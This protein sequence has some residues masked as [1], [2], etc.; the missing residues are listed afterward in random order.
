M[1]GIMIQNEDFTDLYI[2]NILSKNFLQR[3]WPRHFEVASG[4]GW[5]RSAYITQWPLALTDVHHLWFSRR[6]TV[7]TIH[8][9]SG[10]SGIHL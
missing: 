5:T 1:L 2:I 8:S 9:G 7:A 6:A 10:A 4:K 3:D